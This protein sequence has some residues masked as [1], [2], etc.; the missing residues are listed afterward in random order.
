M[1]LCKAAVLCLTLHYTKQECDSLFF[2]FNKLVG[3]AIPR[4]LKPS[5]NLLT[6]Y[7]EFHIAEIDMFNYRNNFQENL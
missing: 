6:M 5:W 1:I 4:V 3:I 2:V 7:K